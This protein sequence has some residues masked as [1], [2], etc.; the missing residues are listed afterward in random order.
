[1]DN[2]LLYAPDE[3]EGYLYY[4]QANKLGRWKARYF[5]LRNQTLYAY[6]SQR[7]KKAA[8]Q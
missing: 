6:K 5:I 7:A 8:K 2:E 3:L 1:M 4:K